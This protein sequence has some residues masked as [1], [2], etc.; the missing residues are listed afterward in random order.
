M[1]AAD[2]FRVVCP[3]CTQ[4]IALAAPG[5]ALPEH[6]LC[7]TPWNPFG[8]TVCAGSGRMVADE[9]AAVAPVP[10]TGHDT[11]LLASLP[12]SLDWRLQPFSHA[13]PDDAA[14]RQAA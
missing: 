3:D 5:T 1:E 8:L 6:A 9:K 12:E 11:A 7:P 4:P 10:R 13:T 2:L 14:L